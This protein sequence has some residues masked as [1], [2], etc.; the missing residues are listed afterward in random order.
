MFNIHLSRHVLMQNLQTSISLFLESNKETEKSNKGTEESAPSSSMMKFLSKSSE[1]QDIELKRWLK[2]FYEVSPYE[3]VKLKTNPKMRKEELKCKDNKANHFQYYRKILYQSILDSKSRIIDM[4]EHKK[5]KQQ[6]KVKESFG[7]IVKRLITGN[8]ADVIFSRDSASNRLAEVLLDL[9][10]LENEQMV[11]VSGI[12]LTSKSY[13]S[14]VDDLKK[15][16]KTTDTETEC[17]TIETSDTQNADISV[18]DWDDESENEFSREL[19]HS[20]SMLVFFG[21]I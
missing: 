1:E 16:N 4:Y 3:Y 12:P 11:D 10:E 8:S 9:K 15:D 7:I 2:L 5:Q 13:E 20:V 14:V 17:T 21:I 6:D 18:L 19:L